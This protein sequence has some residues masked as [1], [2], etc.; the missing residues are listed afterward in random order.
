MPNTMKFKKPSNGHYF[1]YCYECQYY[2]FLRQVGCA[3]EGVCCAIGGEPTQQDAYDPPCGLWRKRE[4][5]NPNRLDDFYKELAEIHKKEF[6]NW[7][8][9]QFC[10]NFLGWLASAKGK[11]PFFPEEKEMIEFVR[12]YAQYLVTTEG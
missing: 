9:G 11:D 2:T 5:R 8:F 6:P 7:R 4:M 12:E 3:Y 1:H 10:C